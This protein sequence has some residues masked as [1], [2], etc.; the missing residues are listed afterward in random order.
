MLCEKCVSV[1]LDHKPAIWTTD[2]DNVATDADLSPKFVS[3]QLP[4]PKRLPENSL[5]GRHGVT[6]PF[7]TFS[8]KGD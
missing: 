2:V 1:E 6:E 7:E 5:R 3:E 8:S 4:A